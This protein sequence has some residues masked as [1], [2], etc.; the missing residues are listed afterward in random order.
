VRE[1][2]EDDGLVNDT[3]LGTSNLISADVDVVSDFAR[4]VEEL[5]SRDLLEDGPRLRVLVLQVVQTQL[6]RPSGD[7][8]LSTEINASDA[9][10]LL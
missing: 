3:L 10:P 8:A 9:L 6:Q 2:V 4:K 1:N 5:L 7:D